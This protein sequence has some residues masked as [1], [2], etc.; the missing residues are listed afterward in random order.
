[1]TPI[2]GTI[3]A[4]DLGTNLGVACGRAGSKPECC[5]VRLK[6]AGEHR[7]VAFSNL[8]D[9][10]VGRF[11]AHL[12]ALVVKEKMLHLAALMKVS[13]GSDDNFRMHAGLHGVVEGLCGRYGVAWTEAADST[14]RKHFL[15]RAKLGDR[16]ATKAAV[17]ARCHLLGL[18]PKGCGDDNVADAAATWDWAA[19]TY[20]RES[21][22]TREL[23]LFGEQ[24]RGAA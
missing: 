15:G 18:L 22:T 23:F 16:A 2:T 21:A 9:F 4:L 10:L 5:S 1:M 7:A 17:V 12:P 24:A 19:A 14:V 20:G 11:E 8:L 3:I 6:T 13:G